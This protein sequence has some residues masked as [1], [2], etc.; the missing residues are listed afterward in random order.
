MKTGKIIQT[1]YCEVE[2]RMDIGEKIKRLRTRNGL[3]QQELA[4]RCELSKGFISQ[5]ESDQT[6]PSI[7][8]LEDILQCLGTNFTEFFSE[9]KDEKVV[10]KKEDAFVK[11]NQESGNEIHWIVPNCQ[12][13]HME[14]I[15]LYLEAGGSS[16]TDGPHDGEEFG[17][18]LSGSV[19]LHL[20]KRKFKV[21]KGECFYFKPA[22]EHYISNES[23]ARAS[24][25]WIST[26]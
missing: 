14:P 15:V 2:D 9:E 20:N 17:Y 23:H 26:E 12:K 1:T 22:T 5:L 4:D 13:N 16:E 6:S 3:T 25:L 21:K 19:I 8:T 10:F 7:A 24:I 11:E 18:V